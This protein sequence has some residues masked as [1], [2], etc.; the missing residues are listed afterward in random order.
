M[1]VD[2][3]SALF[4]IVYRDP[5][6]TMVSFYN[7][8]NMRKVL[9]QKMR[10]DFM[11]QLTF[12]KNPVVWAQDPVVQS[13]FDQLLLRQ[14]TD[15]VSD[16]PSGPAA[17]YMAEHIKG[18]KLRT[19]LAAVPPLIDMQA[20]V[21]T[22]LSAVSVS[23]LPPRYSCPDHVKVAV[24]LIS[25][26]SAVGVLENLE[27]FYASLFHRMED[28]THRSAPGESDH[29]PVVG[30]A[31]TRASGRVR[32]SGRAAAVGEQR[33][34]SPG[35]MSTVDEARVRNILTYREPAGAAES[36]A[37]S[38]PARAKSKGRLSGPGR[39]D[40]VALAKSLAAVDSSD[41][42]NRHADSLF[43]STMLWRLMRAVNRADLVCMH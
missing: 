21:S 9:P 42:R 30:R 14:L 31:S 16:D 20:E 23:K 27:D 26:F 7:Y 11:W 32:A 15:S 22:Y 28:H 2:V 34:Q 13:I 39:P 12:R 3:P 40:Q 5:V 6:S 10:S 24:T 25:R 29:M 17:Q 35:I 38:A 18:Q 33:N 1:Y 4:S 8:V 19:T 36:T 41:S 37:V 43:C